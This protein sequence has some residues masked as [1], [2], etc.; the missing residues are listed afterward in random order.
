MHSLR[1]TVPVIYT[2]VC[3]NIWL[4]QRRDY[5]SDFQTDSRRTRRV[6]SDTHIKKHSTNT[7][8]YS[9]WTTGKWGSLTNP[10]DIYH[11]S[12]NIPVFTRRGRDDTSHLWVYYSPDTW[13][14]LTYHSPKLKNIPELL[15]NLKL[16]VMNE[17][18]QCSISLQQALLR[19]SFTHRLMWYCA[20]AKVKDPFTQ[21]GN[22][23]TSFYELGG[24]V[25]VTT[26][27]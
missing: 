3:G 10:T 27:T 24:Q 2:E 11:T 13:I 23:T 12:D 20:G 17:W 21:Y 6:S 5:S 25:K 15:N 26:M 22:G 19:H 7:G 8:Y 9:V 1:V 4:I 14:C 16:N 18:P